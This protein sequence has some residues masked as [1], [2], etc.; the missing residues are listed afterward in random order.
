[1]RYVA[2]RVEFVIKDRRLW[3]Q[4]G[5]RITVSLAE[6]AMLEIRR[7]ESVGSNER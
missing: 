2:G 7:C 4:Y 5:R 3:E 1:M 6:L